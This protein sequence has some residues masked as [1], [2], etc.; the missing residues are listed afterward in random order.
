MAPSRDPGSG[1][2]SE[3]RRGLWR[4]GY[5]R[6]YQELCCKSKRQEVGAIGPLTG[7]GHAVMPR[8][9]ECPSPH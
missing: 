7:D 1:G 2:P 3:R 6:V 9:L 8:R 5:R 4:S